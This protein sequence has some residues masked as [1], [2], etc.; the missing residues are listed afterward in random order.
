[1]RNFIA[2]KSPPF[3]NLKFFSTFYVDFFNTWGV[4]RAQSQKYDGEGPMVSNN[5][6]RQE[7]T[8]KIFYPNIK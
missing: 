6:L 1:M 7:L 8:Q 4:N 5:C 3:G 2:S